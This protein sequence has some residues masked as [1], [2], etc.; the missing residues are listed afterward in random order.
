MTQPVRLSAALVQEAR[1]TGELMERSIAGQIEYW[2]RLGRAVEGV[3]RGGQAQTLKRRGDVATLMTSLA[4][5]DENRAKV[6]EH[7]AARP[8]PHF[9][10]DED[11]VLVRLD[12]D[13]T[14]TRGRIV[15]R[16]FEP[17]DPGK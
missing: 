2:A 17:L 6:R 7:L 11:G 5:T 13:G 4:D 1:Q 14:R 10:R 15:G 9:T 8:Y 12:E 3:L 16:R